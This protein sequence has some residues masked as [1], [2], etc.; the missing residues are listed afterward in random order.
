[1]KKGAPAGALFVCDAH[2]TDAKRHG[3]VES[4]KL[5]CALTMARPH[6]YGIRLHYGFRSGLHRWVSATTR[7][8]F[9]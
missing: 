2:K 9:R 6:I 1:M 8:R 5:G 4:S 3:G 7:L